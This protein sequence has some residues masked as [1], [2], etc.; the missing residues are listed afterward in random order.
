MI[1]TFKSYIVGLML[2]K[3]NVLFNYVMM[4]LINFTLG[5]LSRILITLYRV[6]PTIYLSVCS[7]IRI[8][9]HSYRQNDTTLK[10]SCDET[11]FRNTLKI[12]YPE[13]YII[14]VWYI[15]FS[16]KKKNMQSN[17]A[18]FYTP[19]CWTIGCSINSMFGN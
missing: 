11:T 17:L 7:I 1:C 4:I 19:L 6:V 16:K 18:V 9:R 10:N 8:Y 3:H 2:F 12:G 15:F 13:S 14:K 5:N